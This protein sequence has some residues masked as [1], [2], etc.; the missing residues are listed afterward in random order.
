VNAI[1]ALASQLDNEI[2]DEDTF[3]AKMMEIKRDAW[4]LRTVA[5][6]DRLMMAQGLA[7]GRP[8]SSEQMQ[9]L[10]FF[11]GRI[12]GEWG[13]VQKEVQQTDGAP[14]KLTDAV[15]AA[16][17]LYFTEFRAQRE[18]AIEAL[19]GHKKPPVSAS[20][21]RP[22][23]ARGQ[24]AITTVANAALNI[25]SSHATDVSAAAMRNFYFAILLMAV[26][27]GMGAMTAFYVFRGVVRPIGKITDTMRLVAAGELD[28]DIPFE[29]RT[30]E[31]GYLARALRVFRDNAIEKQHLR[32]AKEGAEAANRAKS[33]FLAN[34]SH[35]LRTPLNAII[36][37][38]EIIKNQMFGPVQNER[39]ANY[40][41]NIHESGTHLLGLINEVLDMAKLESGQV[42]LHEEEVNVGTLVEGCLRLIEPQ[43]REARVKLSSAIEPGLPRIRVDNRRMRQA[44]LNLISNAVKF[45]PEGGSAAVSA[46]S[47]NGGI[48]IRVSDSGIG[49][50]PEQIPK[51]MEAFGQIDSALSRKYE[52]TGL[53]LP[54]AK[55]LVELHGGTLT[56]ES[57]VG[58]GTTVA[59]ELPPERI[60]AERFEM[61]ALPAPE[62]KSA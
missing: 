5:G 42:E 52:G 27:S 43:A 34:M 56:I 29:D 19:N 21:W 25:A 39:Y 13:I 7:A 11:Q 17:R 37:F 36:G 28:C 9:R 59:I 10:A 16:N 15:A 1:D 38:S 18:A 54:I 62:R 6:D 53:G 23:T 46:A 51:A 50:S 20:Q 22:T 26:F 49:M 30:D 4:A 58:V 33:E 61:A 60:V 48:E 8:F 32:A 41:G 44:L 55:H 2:D 12:D 24:Q 14:A 45:T 40:A 35:E 57:A 31:I 47:K 3:I